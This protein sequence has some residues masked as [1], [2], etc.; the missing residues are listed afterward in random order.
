MVERYS[1]GDTLD[2]ITRER[3]RQ[4]TDWARSYPVRSEVEGMSWRQRIPALS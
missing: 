1:N 2:A 4:I 3:V